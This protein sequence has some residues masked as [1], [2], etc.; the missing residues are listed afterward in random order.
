MWYVLDNAL[1]LPEYLVDF[2]YNMNPKDITESKRL[3]EITQLNDECNQ[4]FGGVA[5]AQKILQSTSQVDSKDRENKAPLPSIGLTTLE[6]DR[7]DMNYVKKPLHKFMSECHIKEL[8]DN[9]YEF[10]D[11]KKNGKPAMEDLMAPEIPLRSQF[12]SITE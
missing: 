10:T 4:L 12:T 9:N 11:D 1:V 2:D 6:I 5:E 8:M 7:S 3:S